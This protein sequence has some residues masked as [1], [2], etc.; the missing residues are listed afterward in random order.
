[1][2]DRQY[3]TGLV[4][5]PQMVLREDGPAPAVHSANRPICKTDGNKVKC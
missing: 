1:M 3:T 4:Q 2:A 5:F